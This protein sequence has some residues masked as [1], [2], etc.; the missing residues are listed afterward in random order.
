MC[1]IVGYVG[2]RQAQDILLPSLSRLEYRGYDSSG[3]AV[4]DNNNIIITKDSYKVEDLKSNIETKHKGLG[5]GHT[6]WATHGEANKANAHPHIS[7]NKEWCVVHNGIIENFAELKNM[8]IENGY[9][10]YSETDSEVIPNLLEYKGVKNMN[11]NFKDILKMTGLK[12]T[13]FSAMK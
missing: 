2:P 11:F 5:I 9:S 13:E 7:N 10:F 3:I 4:K 12:M 6:R 1:G 8:L